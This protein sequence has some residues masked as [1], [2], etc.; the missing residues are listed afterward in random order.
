MLNLGLSLLLLSDPIRYTQSFFG[1]NFPE[2]TINFIWTCTSTYVFDWH[3]YWTVSYFFIRNYAG[4]IQLVVIHHLFWF[5][6]TR[7]R[8]TYFYVANVITF[9]VISE[10]P[11][12]FTLLVRYKLNIFWP[13][14]VNR[15]D[16]SALLF[17]GY[18][19]FIPLF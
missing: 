9:S 12:K 4:L 1:G 17:S 13:L 11:C 7:E 5:Q 19:R 18:T 14:R 2:I 6:S 15:F 16:I 10:L 8:N 3:P